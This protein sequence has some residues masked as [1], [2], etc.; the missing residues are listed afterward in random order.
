MYKAY[1][2]RIMK[3]LKEN[4]FSFSHPAFALSG[5]LGNAIAQFSTSRFNRKSAHDP[6]REELNLP[7]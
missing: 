1:K 5:N 7:V 3:Y 6:N 2:I 4:C